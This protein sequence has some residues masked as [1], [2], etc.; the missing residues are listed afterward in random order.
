ME[1][2]AVDAPDNLFQTFWG[3]ANP[4][5]RWI[6]RILYLKLLQTSKSIDH[7]FL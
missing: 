1:V 5:G 2:E 3:R 4:P 7:R 6:Q